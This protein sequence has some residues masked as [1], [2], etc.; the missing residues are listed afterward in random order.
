MAKKRGRKKGRRKNPFKLSLKK[1]TVY[2]IS[3]TMLFMV[4]GFIL[5]SFAQTGSLLISLNR[6][7]IAYFGW[8]VVFL[9]FI[10]ISM[11]LMLTRLKIR[12]GRPFLDV[13]PSS[14]SDRSG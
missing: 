5:L 13:E 9:P 4:A 12:V 3:S 2:S 1:E 11:G 14:L 8:T 7:L 10:L 6:L